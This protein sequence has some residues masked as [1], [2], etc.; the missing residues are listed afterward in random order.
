MT[1]LVIAGHTT[2]PT[3]KEAMAKM[4]PGEVLTVSTTAS[5]P[6]AAARANLARLTEAGYEKV[7]E[8]APIHVAE[9][10][11]L[12]FDVL[13]RE[14]VVALGE[15]ATRIQAAAPSRVT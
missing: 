2:T 3:A 6:S 10:R 5:T 14:Q 8:A 12:I 13:T 9:V 4:P 15:I 7:M 1:T 11:R